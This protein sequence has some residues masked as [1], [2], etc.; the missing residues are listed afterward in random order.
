[1]GGDTEKWALDLLQSWSG[2]KYIT[3]VTP[4]LRNTDA[5]GIA[6]GMMRTGV[7]VATKVFKVT[8]GSYT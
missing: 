6:D 8:C 5:L 2:A 1:M 4:F 7:T 3:M